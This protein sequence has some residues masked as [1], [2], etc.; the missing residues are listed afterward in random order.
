MEQDKTIWDWKMHSFLLINMF[1]EL[2]VRI[3]QILVQYH[4]NVN[5]YNVYDSK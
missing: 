1:Q 3:S 2:K 5:N 4:R